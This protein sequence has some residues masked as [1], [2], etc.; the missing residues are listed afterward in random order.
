MVT[1]QPP[2]GALTEAQHGDHIIIIKESK[3]CQDHQLAADDMAAA[4][5]KGITNCDR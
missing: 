5:I 4:P 3:I 2:R 1:P